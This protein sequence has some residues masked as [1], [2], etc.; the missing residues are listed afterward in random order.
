MV[1]MVSDGV[2]G[3]GVDW[4]KSELAALSG[5]DV[6]QLCE[7]L[8][9]TAKMRCTDGREDDITVLAVALRRE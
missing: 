9:V 5:D 3:T 4:I 8:A 2:T 6:Q 1:V 7:K